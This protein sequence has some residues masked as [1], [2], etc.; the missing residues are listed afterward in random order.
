MCSPT[1]FSDLGSGTLLRIKKK[2]KK[3]V[4]TA[5]KLSQVSDSSLY[6]LQGKQAVFSLLPGM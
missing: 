1:M 2:K 3:S 5:S 6:G 4:V